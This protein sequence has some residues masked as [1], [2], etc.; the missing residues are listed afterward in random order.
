MDETH[1]VCVS[2]TRDV[3]F[4]VVSGGALQCT[5]CGS[6]AVLSCY[7]LG[8]SINS[9]KRRDFIRLWALS[10]TAPAHRA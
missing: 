10:F 7:V 1:V 5:G 8:S 3:V 2:D 4:V 9:V 6:C